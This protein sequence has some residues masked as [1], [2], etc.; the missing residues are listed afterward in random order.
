MCTHL[1]QPVVARHYANG[2]ERR[3]CGFDPGRVVIDV[4]EFGDRSPG[5]IT[6]MA[7]RARMAIVEAVCSINSTR[8][9]PIV[10]GK[11]DRGGDA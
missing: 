4:S 8:L 9:S 1:H 7:G 10:S 6:P 2:N 3:D 5:G 11:L